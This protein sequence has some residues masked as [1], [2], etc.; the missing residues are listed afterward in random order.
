MRKILLLVGVMLSVLFV[1]A[2]KKNI[3]TL[4]SAAADKIESKTI[5]CADHLRSLGSGPIWMAE[6]SIENKQMITYNNPELVKRCCLLY[7]KQQERKMSFQRR[8]R[9][10][11]RI[12]TSM[13]AGSRRV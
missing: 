12:F 6:L 11:R 10:G 5:T 4:I 3:A 9:H 1:S 2:Q 13:R 7:K 8:H